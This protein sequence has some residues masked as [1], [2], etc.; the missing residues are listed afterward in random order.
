MTLPITIGIIVTYTFHNF[1]NSIAK[2]MYLSFFSLSFSFSLWS[3]STV[4]SSILH[5]L[6][7]LLIIIRSGLLAEIMW[8]VCMSKSHR[9]L[10]VSFSR[11]G[12]G[13]CI[14]HLF[15]WSNINF[16][17]VLL[18]LLLS[19]LLLLLLLLF[20]S[21]RTFQ[22]SVNWWFFTGDWVT[23]YHLTSPGLFSIF[24]TILIMLQS[25]WALLVLW[26]L[27]LRVPLPNFGD[28]YYRTNYC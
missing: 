16:L 19:L 24:L 25:W 26:L 15:V 17:H 22:T 1:F 8:S 13:L 4:K 28:C 18:L 9:S 27:T 3:A 7:S 11:T 23:V 20:Y 6:F 2:L 14:F 12:A 5:G 10:C 21:L